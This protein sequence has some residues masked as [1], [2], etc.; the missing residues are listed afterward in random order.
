M[1]IGLVCADHSRGATLNPSRNIDSRQRCSRDW[2]NHSSSRVRN[3]A[4]TFVERH[5]SKLA[6]F[7]ANGTKD[8]L[9]WKLLVDTCPVR[10]NVTMFVLDQNIFLDTNSFHSVCP[11]HAHRRG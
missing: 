4:S 1:R 8:H 9:T 7:V 5:S 6:P 2:I 11:Q 10:F 3:N